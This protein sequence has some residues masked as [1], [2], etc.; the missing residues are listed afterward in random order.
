MCKPFLWKENF[1]AKSVVE[2]GKTGSKYGRLCEQISFITGMALSFVLF[3][4]LKILLSD[5][6]EIVSLSATEWSLKLHWLHNGNISL[7]L[8]S[9]LLDS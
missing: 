2:H 3:L 8:M 5:I 1:N 7:V 4:M 6:L 9:T